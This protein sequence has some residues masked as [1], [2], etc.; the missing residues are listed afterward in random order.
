MTPFPRAELAVV[1]GLEVG[2]AV[3]GT[4]L[5]GLVQP[6]RRTRLRIAKRPAA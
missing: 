6:P 4:A 2:C 1:D 3:G 5:G